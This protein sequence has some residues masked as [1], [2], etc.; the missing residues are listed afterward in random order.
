M[1]LL[2][3]LKLIQKSD[4][5]TENGS[6]FPELVKNPSAFPAKINITVL[7][8]SSI[9]LITF[10]APTVYGT[11]FQRFQYP[12]TTLRIDTLCPIS[13]LNQQFTNIEQTH[14][15]CCLHCE[16]WTKKERDCASVLHSFK[17]NT[18]QTDEWTKQLLQLKIW[19]ISGNSEQWM[20]FR[21]FWWPVIVLKCSYLFHLFDFYCL[22]EQKLFFFEIFLSISLFSLPFFDD[23]EWE[24]KLHQQN[25]CKVTL[26]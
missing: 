13:N 14:I 1:V 22:L 24:V 8:M 21:R 5:S 17:E 11:S 9:A 3:T 18:Y 16:R 26:P 7:L 10:W 12:S 25:P 4:R 23:F 15:R 19:V 20:E 6:A 2:S